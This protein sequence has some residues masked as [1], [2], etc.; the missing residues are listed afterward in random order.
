MFGLLDLFAK[1]VN[2]QIAEYAAAQSDI[3]RRLLGSWCASLQPYQ[4]AKVRAAPRN[5]G[6]ASEHSPTQ[7]R[8]HI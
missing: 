7:R 6:M 5:P 3:A 2:A 8:R 1:R 4:P